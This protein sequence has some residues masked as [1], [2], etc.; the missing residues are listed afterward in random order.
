M[1][2]YHKSCRSSNLSVIDE[3]RGRKVIHHDVCE[4]C[5]RI[6]ESY[7]IVRTEPITRCV[8]DLSVLNK[9]KF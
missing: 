4:H 6:I 2:P 9:I 8:R 7:E 1:K 5:V 3:Q